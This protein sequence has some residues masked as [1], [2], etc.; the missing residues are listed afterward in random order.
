MNSAESKPRLRCDN[1]LTSRWARRLNQQLESARTQGNTHV[2][3]HLQNRL[4]N[5]VVVEFDDLMPGRVQFGT[6]VTVFSLDEEEEQSFQIVSD[7][8]AQTAPGLI[9]SSAP[10]AQVLLGAIEG[11]VVRVILPNGSNSDYEVTHI[12][13]IPF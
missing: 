10:L 11:D 1:W 12:H 2:A 7:D 9:G 13:L 4:R 3:D 6:R 5:T 8:E